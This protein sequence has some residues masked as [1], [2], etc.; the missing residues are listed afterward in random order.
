M[1]EP[2]AGVSTI[3][4]DSAAIFT[5]LPEHYWTIPTYDGGQ[6]LAPA[7]LL[8]V[9]GSTI[10]GWNDH[11]VFGSL[12]YRRLMKY[13]RETGETFGLTIE[14]RVRTIKQLPSGDIIALIERNDLNQANGMIIKIKN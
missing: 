10:T 9:D 1:A 6:A 4:E 3:S 11:F 8:K 7:C 12:A 5:V 2:I 14:G 13:N